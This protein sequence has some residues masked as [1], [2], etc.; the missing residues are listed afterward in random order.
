M[1]IQLYSKITKNIKK[2]SIL[3]QTAFWARV[4]RK[5]GIES[6]AFDLKVKASDLYRASNSYNFII[7][8]ILILFPRIDDDIIGYVPYG[9]TMKPSDEKKGLFLEELSESLRP[10][11]PPNCVMLRY[12]LLWES[13]WAKD[14]S[15]FDDHGDWTGPPSKSSQEIRL[16]FDTQKWNLKKANTNVLPSDTIFIDLKKDESQLLQEMKAKTRYNVKLAQRKGVRVRRA[17][18]D[19]LDIWYK[20]YQETCARNRICLDKIGYFQAVLGTDVSDTQSPAK[21]ELLIAEIIK[22]PLAAMFLV[23][24]NQRATYLY[25]ASSSL[26]RNYMATYALQWEAIK[27]AKKAGCTEYDMFGVSP[28]PDPSHPL[29]GLYRF[30]IGFGGKLF[31]RMGCWD[32]PLNSSSYERY[33]ITEMKSE[34]YHLH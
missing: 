15:H 1:R 29:Y 25:G 18:I 20:L 2:T 22:I 5:H 6:K 27:R 3:Q 16:N 30:K 19:E 12:D 26:N 9:P 14:R 11:L 24:S 7:D 23:F 21:V 34:G 33:L 8:D 31:H 28:L 4:K 13:L 32:Y 17:N 10:H